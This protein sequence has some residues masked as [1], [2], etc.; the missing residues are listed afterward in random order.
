MKTRG[1]FSLLELLC[2]VAILL[3]LTV[4]MTTHGQASAAKKK[5]VGC[6]GNLEKISV[7]LNLYQNDNHGAYP[8]LITASNSESVLSQLVPQDTAETAIF[9]CPGSD[10][11]EL[12]EG[13]GFAGETISYAYYMGRGTND[14]TGSVIMTDRQVNDSSKTGGQPLFS[15][16]GK[17]PGNNHGKTGGNLLLLNGAVQFSIPVSDRDLLLNGNLRLLNP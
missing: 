2:T 7:A 15:S 4:V 13:R 12:P 9:I 10:D 1:A 16:T 14:D 6:E 5:R 11:K 17:A 3:I 8:L